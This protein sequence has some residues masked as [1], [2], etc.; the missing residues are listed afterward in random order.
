MAREDPQLFDLSALAA[1][2]HRSD[3]PARMLAPLMGV[4]AFAAS[5]VVY[6]AWDSL[7]VAS[8][9]KLLISGFLAAVGVFALVAPWVIFRPEARQLTVGSDGVTIVYGATNSVTHAWTKPNLRIEIWDMR[10]VP[11]EFQWPDGSRINWSK[12]R[13]SF[14]LTPEAFDALKEVARSTSTLAV[15]TNQTSTRGKFAG[16]V[17][18]IR[19]AVTRP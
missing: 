14:W 1:A 19:P 18:V 3:L 12:P 4:M 11:L 6:W 7:F 9:A 13:R 2:E 8:P 15:E 16:H 17:T 5:Y 10:E